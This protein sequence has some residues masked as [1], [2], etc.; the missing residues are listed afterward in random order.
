MPLSSDTAVHLAALDGTEFNLPAQIVQASFKEQHLFFKDLDA[1]TE[2]THD[3]TTIER[4]EED[5]ENKMARDTATG[6]MMPLLAEFD[7]ATNTQP[8]PTAVM[9]AAFYLIT[10]TLLRVPA[11][12]CINVKQA[13]TL[14]H[15]ARW[16]HCCKTTEWEEAVLFF[17]EAGRPPLAY[18][19]RLILIGAAGTGKSTI[20]RIVE[21][22]A[23][24]FF[25]PASVRKGAPSNAAA[26]VVGGDTIH[27]LCKL[28]FVGGLYGG[29]KSYLSV[30]V[31][32]A[33]KE[34]WRTAKFIYEGVS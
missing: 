6:W 31:L 24:K 12:G 9:E 34:R 18:Q 27:A 28:P 33:F 22:L 30:P 8:T 32:R 2:S 21:A 1:A 20:L 26:R 4:F 15:F 16:I 29:A 17:P 7:S 25:G 23:D 11:T 10:S 5:L 19:L 14:L 13:L 3:A